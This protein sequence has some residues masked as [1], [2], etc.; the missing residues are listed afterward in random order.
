[1]GNPP[2]RRASVEGGMK[3]LFCYEKINRDPPPPKADRQG[4]HVRR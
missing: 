1:M 3:L 2:R 4:G